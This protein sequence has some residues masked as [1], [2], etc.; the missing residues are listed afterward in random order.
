MNEQ[1]RPPVIEDAPATVREMHGAEP[2]SS[3]RAWLWLLIVL[4]LG[5]GLYYLWPRKSN[6][7]QSGT[8]A[9]K[10]AGARV[11]GA[12]ITPV[13][14]AKARK[15]DVGVYLTG[16]GAVT[17]LYTV[18]VKTRVDGQL[19]QIHYREGD[20]VHEGDLLAE[21]DPRPY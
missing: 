4:A 12:G 3:R 1:H 17:P 9:S 16:L 21:I 13:V 14:A 2:P 19:I 6:E 11:R 7:A 10:N 5:A 8:A 15:G 18:T 20:T